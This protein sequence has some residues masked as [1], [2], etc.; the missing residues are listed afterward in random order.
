MALLEVADLTPFAPD[1]DAT[2]AAAMIA[3]AL[4]LATMV[5]PCLSEE[6]PPSLSDE[7]KAA[8]K[9]I[10]RGAVLRWND[11]GSGAATSK[12]AGPFQIAFDNR[13]SRKSMFWPSEITELQR[14]CK[15]GSDGGAFSVDTAAA[16]IAFHS[17]LCGFSGG[18]VCGSSD[19]I[20][21]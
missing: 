5:A 15:G 11:S 3:D 1:I 14:I 16:P 9:A 18:C 4:A 17:E 7:Q 8:A 6:L 10:V 19:G 21:G 13:Q 12:A 2:K 20:Y